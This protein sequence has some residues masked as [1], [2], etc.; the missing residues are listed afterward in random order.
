MEEEQ[1]KDNEI[2][3]LRKRLGM[4]IEYLN[5]GDQADQEMAQ[6]TIA[7]LDSIDMMKEGKE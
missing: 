2:T 7:S 3:I 5:N 4:V 6:R 1:L